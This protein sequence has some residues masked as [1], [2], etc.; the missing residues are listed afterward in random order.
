M[1]KVLVIP[2]IKHTEATINF[3][4]AI[5]PHM[6]VGNSDGLGY[7]AIDK[8]GNLFAERWFNNKEAFTY[9]NTLGEEI[10]NNRFG[11]GVSGSFKQF[12][13]SC[14]G[15]EPSLNKIQAI[16]LHTRF[17]TCDKNL[18]NVHPFIKDDTSVIHNGVISNHNDFKLEV[19]TCDSESILQ[20]YLKY[21]VGDT[22]DVQSVSDELIG[23]YVAALF[24]RDSSGF[25][26]LDL[27]NGNNTNLH[28]AF[29]VE[30]DTYVITTSSF[31][32]D[33]AVKECGYTI[34]TT[35][36]FNDGWY[37]RIDPFSGDVI[38]KEQFKVGN[39]QSYTPSVSKFN[40]RSYDKPTTTY[41]KKKSLSQEE[42][43]YLKLI[44]SASKLTQ[45]EIDEWETIN[46]WKEYK[47]I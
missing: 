26:W 10:I 39:R 41:Y 22:K 43:E 46:G 24:S 31:D 30:L 15:D 44:P 20:S 29:V 4:K 1:C 9:K 2:A 35:F 8:D 47:V 6:S 18:T 17:A 14:Y 32:L 40:D 27:F 34:S 28:V 5:T 19:S 11:R 16:T 13:Y 42:F 36:S 21:N 38:H 33:K 25:R 7:A 12:D 37:Y 45:T 3:I 23:Y